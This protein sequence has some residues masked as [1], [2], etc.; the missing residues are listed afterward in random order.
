M[1]SNTHS[2]S[3]AAPSSTLPKL[4]MDFNDD[5]EDFDD[6]VLLYDLQR[7]AR[8]PA[9]RL[10]HLDPSEELSDAVFKRHYRFDKAGV[11]RIAGVLNLERDNDRGRPLTPLQQVCL[12][13]NFY[14]GGHY[15]R[16]AGLCSGVSQSAAWNAIERVTNELCRIK[17]QV[18]QLPS[19]QEVRASADRNYA[20][21]GLPR[22]FAGVD[23]V[24]M[25][26]EEKPRMIPVGTVA[27]DFFN[28]KMCYAINVQVVGNDEHLILDIVADWQ[29]ANHD[30]R[31][32][33]NSPVKGLIERQ[34]EF[35]I[36]GDSGYPISDVLMKPYPNREALVDPRK[37]EFNT[38]LSR[39]R[40]VST[41]N[42]FGIMK[43]KFPILKSLRA[44]HAR[45]RRVIYAC[46]VLHNLSVRWRMEDEDEDEDDDNHDPA[47]P[48]FERI[49]IVADEAPL[50]V[51]R[52]RGQ[53]VRDQLMM[54]MRMRGE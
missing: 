45:A 28:R 22:F 52:E 41:E 6:F 13:L 33:D 40:T 34:R 53:I 29:G 3:A 38:R 36:A 11:R 49:P 26:F 17:D 4:T 1:N 25:K 20:R 30:A 51:I 24:I 12:A 18:I 47:V 48:H 27:Q 32:W 21:F 2:L 16:V 37:A 15:T 42:I 35:L 14:G 7:R 10:H 19:D 50:H 43:R 31:I 54:G 5:Y 9:V 46:A 23:G 39:L 44:H 8:A